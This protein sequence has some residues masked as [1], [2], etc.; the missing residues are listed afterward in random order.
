MQIPFDPCSGRE[1]PVEL[2]FVLFQVPFGFQQFSRVRRA[3]REDSHLICFGEEME[4]FDT[5]VTDEYLVSALLGKCL[6]IWE[7]GIWSGK[8]PRRGLQQYCFGVG[9]LQV[10]FI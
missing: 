4:G 7:S 8:I 6:Q 1:H 3:P 10:Q 9:F 2:P 5:E